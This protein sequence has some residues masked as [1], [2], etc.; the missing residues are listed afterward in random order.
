M[1]GPQLL[2]AQPRLLV[3]LIMDPN[4]S[5]ADKVKLDAE[6]KDKVKMKPDGK[7]MRR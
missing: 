2:L 4:S 5:T 6:M 3:K 7:I 1:G